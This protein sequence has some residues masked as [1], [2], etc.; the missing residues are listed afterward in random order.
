VLDG[1]SDALLLGGGAY[2]LGHGDLDRGQFASGEVLA[3]C[4]AALL[5][6][7][8]VLEQLGGM[9][10][11]FF[12]YLDDID[13]ALRAQLAGHK[14][15]YVAEARAYHQGSATLGEPLHPK[16]VEWITRNQIFLLIKDY[17]LR[18]LVHL[19]P[20]ILFF[21]ALWKL[22]A[23]REGKLSSHIRGVLGAMRGFGTLLRKRRQVQATRRIS[24]REFLVILRQ[25]ENQIAAWQQSMPAEKRSRLLSAYFRVFGWPKKSSSQQSVAGA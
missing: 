9:D 8:T 19:L 22:R 1:A 6:R 11:L 4:G 25:S 10:E 5:V 12:A 23:L 15:T 3:C 21:Q 17:P 16:M 14:V 24:A 7:R 13:L 18:L 2:R 20:R